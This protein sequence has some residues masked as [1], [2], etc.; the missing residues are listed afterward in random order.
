MVD[1]KVKIK[2]L[3]VE[4]LSKAL[5][6]E[7][8]IEPNYESQEKKP[9]TRSGVLV[10]MT[11]ELVEILLTDVNAGME[12]YSFL[13]TIDSEN[14][15]RQWSVKTGLT[16]TS[17]KIN[18]EK[19]ITAA[20]IDESGKQFLAVGNTGGEVQVLNMKSGG[21]LYNLP[22]CDSE[23]TSLK[24]LSGSKKA[25]IIHLIVSEFWLVGGCWGGKLMMWTGPND[26]NNFTVLGRCRIGHR[27]D[28]LCVDNSHQFIASGGID[29]LLSIWNMMT[30]TLKYAIELPPPSNGGE[31][32]DFNYEDDC[33]SHSSAEPI[34]QDKTISSD[35]EEDFYNAKKSFSIDSKDI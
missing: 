20:A 33:V 18:M 8:A 26:A 12:K 32:K 9:E 25:R 11:S 3:Q 30:G 7:R 23:V 5:L 1:G 21:V 19:R 14:L 24:F 15:L 34:N 31:I 28:I 29:G 10:S 2:A 35:G 22:S 16:T 13:I 4:T 27:N 6:K 17:Y